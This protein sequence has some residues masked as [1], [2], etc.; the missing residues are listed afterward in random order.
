M[1]DEVLPLSDLSDEDLARL[2]ARQILELGVTLR[3]G[4]VLLADAD[5]EIR[6]YVGTILETLGVTV[7]Y[8]ATADDADAALRAGDFNLV[9]VDFC[10]DAAVGFA[11]L[12]R[13]SHLGN[14]RGLVLFTA[15]SRAVERIAAQLEPPRRVEDF[16]LPKPFDLE[17]DFVPVLLSFLDRF[18]D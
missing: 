13:L 4:R 2:S 11:V 14:T 16:W 3:P 5:A 1:A 7:V 17:H 12:E 10:E 6:A 18:E 9:L 8:A 15:N